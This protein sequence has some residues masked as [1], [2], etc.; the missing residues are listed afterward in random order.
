[1]NQ[2]VAEEHEVSD[3]MDTDEI[4][5]ISEISDAG[6]NEIVSDSNC[7]QHFVAN[8]F[9]KIDQSSLETCIIETSV[10]QNLQMDRRTRVVA[11]HKNSNTSRSWQIRAHSFA[12]SM[13]AVS[14]KCGGGA[15]PKY[16]WYG[17]SRD[18]ICEIVTHG[19]SWA[20]ADTHI[21]S[22]SPA[23]HLLDSVLRSTVDESGLR[24]LLLCRVI[25]GKQEVVI[26]DSS[27][28]FHPSSSEFDSGVDDISAPR[29]YIVWNSHLNF[30]VFPCYIVSLDV[31]YLSGFKE[32]TIMKPRPSWITFH[33]LIC[34][35]SR[36]LDQ[37][38][39]AYLKKHYTDFKEKRITKPQMIQ[40]V[41]EI[42]GIH[43]LCAIL[44]DK[45]L[46]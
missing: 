28:Q 37:S 20:A 46:I 29:K 4:S 10:A 17:A 27:H 32:A 34:I 33:T 2:V 42:A 11:I 23:K 26:G 30:S 24:H 25:L 44:K 6:S 45:D 16:A 7:F 41:K 19:F 1:M 8:G 5:E 13:K 40:R 15:N 22:L 39:M 21:I 9:S 31:P 14:D 3:I 12:V 43:F 18:E 36:Y 35:L 38:R